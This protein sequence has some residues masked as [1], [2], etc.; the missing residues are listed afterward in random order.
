VQVIAH[1]GASAEAAEHTFRAYD[2]ALAQGADTLELD[3]RPTADGDLV[4]VHD[5]TL[6]RTAGDPR[7]V[8][9]LPTAALAGLDP[10]V[11]PLLL[12]DVLARYGRTTRWLVELKEPQPAWEGRA[13]AALVRHGVGDLAVVQSFDGPALRRLRRAA[14]WLAVAPLARRRR[15]PGPAFLDRSARYA[16]GIGV[17]HQA[18]DLALVAA[19]HARG[20][21]VRAFTVNE[22]A[23][24]DRLLALGVD[25]LI[26]DLPAAARTA[27]GAGTLALAAQA[28]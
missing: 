18:V 11:R 4:V 10:A 23:E 8:G 25:G 2:L 26:T 22:P 6:A 20:L 14:P 12:D 9:E 3:V 24:M 5:R 27:C 19:A 28:A 13:V 16:D 15:V 1:R 17:W 7:R 21:A